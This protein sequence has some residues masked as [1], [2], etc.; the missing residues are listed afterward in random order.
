MVASDGQPLLCP[1]VGVHWWPGDGQ[2]LCPPGVQLRPGDGQLLL[3]PLGA[4]SGLVMASCC[5][6]QRSNG[7][8]VMASFCCVRQGSSGGLVMVTFDSDFLACGRNASVATVV[9]E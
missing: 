2:L 7:G 6:C 9:G 4:Q 5:V 1:P 3:C 8:L